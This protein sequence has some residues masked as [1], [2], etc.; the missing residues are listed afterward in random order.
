[1]VTICLSSKSP[2]CCFRLEALLPPSRSVRPRQPPLPPVRSVRPRRSPVKP[3]FRLSGPP[4]LGNIFHFC[5]QCCLWQIPSSSFVTPYDF[6]RV[7]GLSIDI[8][9]WRL[10][11]L[12]FPDR[13]GFLVSTILRLAPWT[14]FVFFPTFL[15]AVSVSSSIGH[16][17]LLVIPSCLPSGTFIDVYC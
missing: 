16:V 15:F 14:A 13:D 9:L 8:F 11:L 2:I 10:A 5:C 6:F 12:L 17:H 1:M 4:G 3:C 7:D